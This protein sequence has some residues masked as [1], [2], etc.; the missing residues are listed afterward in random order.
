MPI[1]LYCATLPGEAI[2]IATGVCEAELQSQELGG[3]RVYWSEI[4]NPEACFGDAESL[5]KATSQFQQ[6][7]RQILA[8]TTPLPFAFPT[9]LESTDSMDEFLAAERAA[10]RSALERIG[11]AVQYEITAIWTADDQIDMAAPVSGRE[12]VKRRHEVAQRTAA[13]DVKLK[14]VT[15]DAVREW[16]SR[17]DRKRHCWFALVSRQ[18]R[19]RFVAS[20]RS[21]GPSQGV[22][23]RLSGPW[24]PTEFVTTQDDNR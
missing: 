7:L 4:S 24:P 17:Q 14:S 11:D 22:R 10:Y 3:L 6:V 9:L 21:A 16:R 8:V 12:Y 23:L 2:R 5:K 18:Q 19:E 15:G 13:V 20:L 1:L